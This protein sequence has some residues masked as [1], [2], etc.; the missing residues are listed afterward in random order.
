[1]QAIKWLAIAVAG[2]LVG[3]CFYPWFTFET[4]QIKIG[5]FYSDITDFGKPGIVHVIVCALY[6]GLIL[7]Q[8]ARSVVFAFLISIVNIIWVAR[9]FFLMSPC[10]G[11]HCPLIHVA[12][13]VLIVSSILL[14]M[15]TFRI[16]LRENQQEK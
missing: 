13:Y 4:E 12:F 8:K 15:L 3:A 9:N 5:G 6:V 10:K 2:I 14:T 16:T 11:G 7:I 1:M